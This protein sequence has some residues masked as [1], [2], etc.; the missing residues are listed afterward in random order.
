M[1]AIGLLL[2]TPKAIDIP[3]AIT[4][5]R[6]KIDTIRQV[7][8]IF[9]AHLLLPIPRPTP[10]PSPNLQLIKLMS[11][12]KNIQS[13]SLLIPHILITLL[14]NKLLVRSFLRNYCY[15]TEFLGYRVEE[16]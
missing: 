3:I 11:R 15:F 10:S 5:K 9:Q 12:R 2:D 8:I 6:T 4:D 7:L 14:K 1:S 16:S 13:L